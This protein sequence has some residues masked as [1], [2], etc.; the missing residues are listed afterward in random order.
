[1]LLETRFVGRK[2][3]NYPSQNASA[4][5]SQHVETKGH[6]TSIGMAH[7]LLQTQVLATGHDD[8]CVTTCARQALHSRNKQASNRSAVRQC[9][10][11]Q[12]HERGKLL[13]SILSSFATKISSSSARISSGSCLDV[14][15][16]FRTCLIASGCHFPLYQETIATMHG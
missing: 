1:V 15:E 7:L 12:I 9:T 2:E 10:S 4:C 14:R 3:N 5:K 11:H 8:N 6:W 16:I 13:A